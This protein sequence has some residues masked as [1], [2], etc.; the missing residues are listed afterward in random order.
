M[1]DKI[2]I[3]CELFMRIWDRATQGDI[4]DEKLADDARPYVRLCRL[5]RYHF[6][7]RRWF[8]KSAGNTYHSVRIYENGEL[9]HSSGQHYGY[10]EQYLQTAI[11]WLR[12]W[13]TNLPGTRSSSTIYLREELHATW[14]VADVSRERDL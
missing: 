11:E 12:L 2:E 9:I 10:G 13:N 5:P 8:Q 4:V 3:P 1:R 14:E 7:G 6:E